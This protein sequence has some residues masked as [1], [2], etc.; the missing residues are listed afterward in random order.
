MEDGVCASLELLPVLGREQ[1]AELLAA[2]LEKRGFSRQGETAVRSEGEGVEVRVDLKT[3]E[4]TA[5]A[6]ASRELALELQRSR[7]VAPDAAV[8][9]EKKL[10]GELQAQLDR[11][12]SDAEAKLRQRTS[13]GLEATL[14]GLRGELDAIANRVTAEALKRKA[15]ELGTIEEISEDPQTGSLTIKVKV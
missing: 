9:E 15:A 6:T 5:T 13:A 11:Q 8:A 7:P 3:G 10:R 4:V 2:E 1:M 12:A 14:K